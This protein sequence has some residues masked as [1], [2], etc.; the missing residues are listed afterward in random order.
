MFYDASKPFDKVN[1]WT[2]YK[3]S[4]KRSVPSVINRI[5]LFSYKAQYVCTTWGQCT[6][7]YF[8]VSNGLIKTRF[9]FVSASILY[10][11]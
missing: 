5:L 6:S 3:N 1:H 2:L 10:I 11:C 8:N 7:L 4:M 9:K